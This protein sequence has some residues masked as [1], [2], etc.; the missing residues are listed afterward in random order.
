MASCAQKTRV[1]S[2]ASAF[3]L[4]PSP[5]VRPPLINS[6]AADR[7]VRHP[8]PVKHPWVAPA[9]SFGEAVGEC[10]NERLG[11]FSGARDCGAPSITHRPFLETRTAARFHSEVPPPTPPPS[12]P[13]PPTCCT[14][15]YL[16]CMTQNVNPL[17]YT[18]IVTTCARFIGCCHAQ[19]VR[20]RGRECGGVLGAAGQSVAAHHY[21]Q[22][23]IMSQLD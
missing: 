18:E 13:P 9:Q 22:A 14:A 10:A 8:K 2:A 5:L 19:D 17:T 3:H 4:S 6:G 15:A 16:F 21:Y 23:R 1:D 11:A 7:C 12:A 20:K